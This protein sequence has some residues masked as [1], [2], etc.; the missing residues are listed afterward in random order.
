MLNKPKG[1]KLKRFKADCVFRTWTSL[2]VGIKS[3][4]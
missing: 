3:Q 4:S 2:S 1:K